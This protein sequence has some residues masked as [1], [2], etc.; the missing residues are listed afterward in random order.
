MYLDMMRSTQLLD[1][2]AE[3]RLTRIAQCGW[4]LEQRAAELAETLGHEPSD[5]HIAADLGLLNAAHA[6]LIMV[7]GTVAMARVPWQV[8]G[9]Q[10][11]S[12]GNL[13]W[14]VYVMLM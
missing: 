3:V 8:I 11:C 1:K 14:R 5:S 9:H 12:V 2:D 10:D 4:Q 13:C 7:S 6:K